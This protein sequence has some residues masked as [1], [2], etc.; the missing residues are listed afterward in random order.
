MYCYNCA[1]VSKT[2]KRKNNEDNFLINSVFAPP[3]HGDQMHEAEGNLSERLIAAVADGMG[4]EE[5][6]E[7]ASFTAMEALNKQF[8]DVSRSSDTDSKLLCNAIEKAQEGIRGHI[9]SE[10]NHL[11]MGSTIVAAVFFGNQVYY[12]GMGDS[13]IYLMRRGKLTLLTKDHT[14]GQMLIDSG[15]MSKEMAD[16]HPG[17]NRLTR[18]LG[19]YAED[20]LF[21]VPPCC[22]LR[23]REGDTFLLCSDGVSAVLAH[24]ELSE[25]LLKENGVKSTA[26]KIVDA[27]LK[28]GGT[29]NTTALVI[30]IGARGNSL[31]KRLCMGMR[32]LGR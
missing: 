14:E 23:I 18:F 29:D 17:S 9:D 24:N 27:A 25:L 7:V 1:V 15:I 32:R 28:K 26:E 8:E 16:K 3:D 30:R 22:D 10:P 31:L 5:A 6:G 12:T 19:M 2:N 21:E 11:G 4:G 13:R 20:M